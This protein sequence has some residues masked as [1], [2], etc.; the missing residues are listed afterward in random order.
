MPATWV[1]LALHELDVVLT[2]S[3]AADEVKVKAF[4]HLLGKCGLSFFGPDQV[5][6]ASDSPFDPEGGPLYIRETIKVI[7]NLDID[8]VERQKIY[9]RNAERLFGRTF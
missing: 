5:M 8:G 9:S 7:D 4:N 6:F 1:K 2:D 3:P